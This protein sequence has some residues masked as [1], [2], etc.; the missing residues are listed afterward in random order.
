MFS[1][2]SML[3]DINLEWK[4]IGNFLIYVCK[5]TDINT[6]IQIQRYTDTHIN[7]DL[8]LKSIKTHFYLS[9][10]STFVEFVVFFSFLISLS[11]DHLYH[12]VYMCVYNIGLNVWSI[13]SVRTNQLKCVQMIRRQMKHSISFGMVVMPK[14]KILKFC[15]KDLSH[16]KWKSKKKNM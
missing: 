2:V 14:K 12:R 16:G 15:S 6:R 3:M 7:D 5:H 9:F 11:C 1:F 13:T 10:F 8:A 4:Y